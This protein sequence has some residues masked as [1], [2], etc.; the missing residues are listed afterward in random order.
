MNPEPDHAKTIFL[1]AIEGQ[2]PEKWEAYLDGAC[3]DDAPLRSRVSALLQA[4]QEMGSFREEAPA[5]ARTIDMPAEP[6]IAAA[7]GTVIGP[8][9]LLQQIGEGGMGVVYMAEQAAPVRRKV[10]LKIIKPGMDTR[11]V[12][13][14][15]EAE[16]QALALM[17]HPNIARVFDAGATDAGRPYFVME[18]VRGVPITDYCDQNNLPI[19]ERLE[20]FITVCHAVQHAHQKGI[21]HR[22]IKPSN[23][24]VTLHD[25][26]PVPKVIDFGVAKAIGQ[27]LTDKTLF[28]QFAQMVGTPLYMSPEQAELTG[29]D[30]DTRGDIYSL[31]VM[32]YELLT[33][34]TPFEGGRMK[35]AALDEIRRMIREEDPPSPSMRLSST[36]GEAQTAVAAHRHIDPKGLSRLVRGDL[37]WIVM[38]ALEKDRTRRYET[39]NGFAA[40]I[41]RY[42]SDEPVEACPPSSTYRFRKFARRNRVAFS[43]AALVLGALVVG[44]FVSTWQA[45]RATH[46]EGLAEAQRQRAEASEHDA[47]TKEG[48]AQDARKEAVDSLKEALA[49]VDQMLTRVG[50]DRLDNVPQME[51]V[52]RELLQD[53][54]KFYQRFLQKNRDD[55]IIG[56]EAARA[57]QRLGEIQRNLGQYA[58]SEQNYRI[59]F[60][61]FE[62]QNAQAPL[63]ASFRYG[64]SSAH[65]NQA[66][67]LGELGKR[68]E[69]EHQIHEATVIAEDLAN[70]FPQDPNFRNLLADAALWQ[71]TLIFATQPA[72]AEKILRRNLTLTDDQRHLMDSY[73]VLGEFLASQGRSSEAEQALRQSLAACEQFAA[74]RPLAN[75]V[76]GNRGATL[77]ELSDVVAATGRLEE[78]EEISDRAIIILDKLA[79][80]FPEGPDFRNRQAWAYQKRATLL[81]K[82]NRTAEAEQ[83]YR[84]AL[85]L[86]VKL[87]ANFPTIRAYP[88]TAFDQRYSLGQFL[89]EGGRTADAADVYLQGAELPA[90]RAGVVS[91]N[92]DPWH[93]VFRTNLELGRL[94]AK[95]GKTEESEAAYRRAALSQEKLESDFA[96]KPDARRY[97]AQSHYLAS[98]VF[99]DAG[100]PHEA[101]KLARLAISNFEKLA[102]D[103]PDLAG[104][105]CEVAVTICWLGAPLDS[106]GR[107]FEAEECNHKAVAILERLVIEDPAVPFYRQFLASNFR[108]IGDH[109]TRDGRIPEAERSYRAAIDLCET[110]AAEF[111]DD[112]QHRRELGR[113]R[114]S[115]GILLAKSGRFDEAE[116]VHQQA[117]DL[118]QRLVQEVD[119]TVGH[120]H[121][122]ELAWTYMNLGSLLHKCRRMADGEKA[123]REAIAVLEKLDTEFP[124]Q[125]YA[126]WLANGYTELALVLSAAAQTQE[127]DQTYRKVLEL[128]PESAPAM[129]NLAWLLATC[130]KPGFRNPA[131]A[132]EL[133]AKAVELAPTERTHWNTLGV[134]QYYAGDWKAAIE[135]LEK[136]TALGEGG[137]SFDW[138]F[139]AMA[140]WQ[141]DDKEEAR[142]KFDHALTWMEK[143]QPQNE[144]LQRFRAEAEELLK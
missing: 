55:P 58:E 89:I 108:Y 82:L 39:A 114:N 37:D 113:C 31:G 126:G 23:V 137:D 132:V 107:K 73:R 44:T 86:F 54:L 80:D 57:Y 12:I 122:R 20:L 61:M 91:T 53:A 67:S 7:P 100:R 47:K 32:L 65:L 83:A 4:H 104:Y 63:D 135:A 90:K 40:D 33:G 111:P 99:A 14:R 141:S 87:A 59:A 2:S 74:E 103:F 49:A 16:R 64:L 52:R 134:A 130:E 94:L 46:A 101:E 8:Y 88:Q 15:F 81:R 117:L 42:L 70:E 79:L 77:H 116:Q 128:K 78:A 26:R 68:K 105:R 34:T 28:T 136:S 11:E 41:V 75:W 127:A 96:D 48:L 118:Y 98:K 71:A 76:Q 35:K 97:L 24:L 10:A 9:K 6:R 120:L 69:Q 38:K 106:L 109:Q 119:P 18:L 95:N 1:R 139:L 13:A 27:Q 17:D 144:E 45:I 84:R 21:I 43:T 36:A 25:G 112:R 85:E 30:I 115:L 92:L 138:F 60:A 29:L 22:D 66:F 93:G 129:N 5:V 142:I 121:R 133:A 56:R 124:T 19:H 102:A 131:R 143:N 110:L 72:E 3:G 50:Q 125:G 140:H 123:F 62:A 51:P